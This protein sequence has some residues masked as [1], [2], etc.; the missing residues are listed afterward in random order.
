VDSFRLRLKTEVCN[1]L[2]A[3]EGEGDGEGG[4]ELGTPLSQKL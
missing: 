4:G 2:E 3:G 1:L